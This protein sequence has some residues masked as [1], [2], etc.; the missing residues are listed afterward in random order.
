MTTKEKVLKLVAAYRLMKE[1]T[2][3]YADDEILLAPMSFHFCEVYEG[4]EHIART[5][6]KAIISDGDTD[7]VEVE[8]VMFLE[9]VDDKEGN[10]I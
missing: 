4:I 2:D 7:K 9:I 1:A 5:F 3:S 8:N 6:N 10:N